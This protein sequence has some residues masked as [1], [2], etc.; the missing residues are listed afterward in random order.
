MI[1]RWWHRRRWTI[2]WVINNMS[3]VMLFN[4]YCMTWMM[5]FNYNYI[6][7]VL[8]SIFYHYI[9]SAMFTYQNYNDD[10]NNQNNEKC[11]NAIR[12][13]DISSCS[14]IS[15][16]IISTIVSTYWNICPCIRRWIVRVSS[17]ICS[18][19]SISSLA[20]YFILLKCYDQ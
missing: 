10:Q 8:K 4:N 9:R 7:M 16:I 20:F 5:L 15:P 14:I 6:T 3:R 19:S 2:N 13:I 17:W 11:Q 12:W 1:K 18:E